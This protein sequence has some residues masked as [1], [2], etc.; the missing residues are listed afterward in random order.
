VPL[1]TGFPWNMDRLA[2]LTDLSHVTRDYGED[3][4]GS[5]LLADF[6]VTRDGKW[7]K[8]RFDDEWTEGTKEIRFLRE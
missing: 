4:Q 6:E 7:W 1:E 8:V 2:Y 3:R 5:H